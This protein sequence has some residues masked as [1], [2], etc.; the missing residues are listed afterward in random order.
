MAVSKDDIIEDDNFF[1]PGLSNIEQFIPSA[2][3]GDSLRNTV[4]TIVTVDFFVVLLLLGWFL[5]GIFCSS[6][7]KNDFV[8][9]AFNNNFNTLVQPALGILMIGSAAGAVWKEEG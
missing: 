3:K 2:V 9:I 7:L 6:I 1:L 8:Q 4:S 5:L